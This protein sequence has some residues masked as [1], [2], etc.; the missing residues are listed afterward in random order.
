MTQITNNNAEFF[1]VVERELNALYIPFKE[2]ATN[3]D[4]LEIKPDDTEEVIEQKEIDAKAKKKQ[5][6][7]IRTA[8]EKCA[9]NARDGF[10]NASKDV[11]ALEK[12]YTGKIKEIEGHLKTQIDYRKLRAERVSKELHDSRVL[13][14]SQYQGFYN[15]IFFG[16]MVESQWVETLNSA[17]LAKEAHLKSEEDRVERE[18]KLRE[19]RDQLQK[20]A[21]ATRRENARLRQEAQA[22]ESEEAKKSDSVEARAGSEEVGSGEAIA[23]GKELSKLIN[24]ISDIIGE[25]TP[26]NNPEELIIFDNAITLLRKTIAYVEFNSEGS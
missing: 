10:N 25:T 20:E 7:P 1:E 13:E 8:I 9:K 6:T 26:P 11:I 3:L 23:D 21:E 15:P 16:G 17:K 18:K 5:F 12:K 19:E 4:Y 14:I 2:L 22:K 24:R